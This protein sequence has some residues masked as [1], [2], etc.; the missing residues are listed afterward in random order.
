MLL[1]WAPGPVVRQFSLEVVF[2]AVFLSH[3]QDSS[4]ASGSQGR[5]STYVHVLL[6]YTASA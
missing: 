3:W 6:Q 1:Y 5:Y 2:F 4:P